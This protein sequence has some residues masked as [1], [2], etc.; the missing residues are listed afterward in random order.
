MQT[1]YEV[2]VLEIDQTEMIHKLE[3]LGASLKFSSLQKRYVYDFYP[4]QSGKWIRLRTNGQKTTLTIKDIKKKTIDGTKELEI[5]VDDFEKTNQILLELG[6]TPKGF[7]ENRR[8]Q[9]NLDGVEI[10]FDTW[11]MLPTYMEIEGKNEK[12]VYQAMEKLEISKEKIATLDV[13]SI[14]GLYGHSK[15]EI[16]DLRFEREE[17][18]EKF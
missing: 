13:E 17:N 8:I 18:N 2:R 1:E 6:Y 3:S 10:D 11:P 14:Y 12:E 4:V 15:E 5:V 16:T 7:Q 9:Y